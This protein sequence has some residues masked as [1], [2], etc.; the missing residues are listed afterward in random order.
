MLRITDYTSTFQSVDHFL[1]INITSSERKPVHTRTIGQ[2]KTVNGLV[3]GL[4]G[5]QSN[6]D[7]IPFPIGQQKR[8]KISLKKNK[9][10]TSSK[11]G[12]YQEQH[13]FQHRIPLHEIVVCSTEQVLQTPDFR[14]AV[15]GMMEIKNFAWN[16]ISACQFF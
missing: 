6:D 3:G 10:L 2:I 11:E 13:R 9:D 14:K 12:V 16:F 7:F 5:E 1:Y 4:R 8:K 15:Q